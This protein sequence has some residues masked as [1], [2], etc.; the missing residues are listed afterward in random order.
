MTVNRIVQVVATPPF[1]M[2]TGS[3]ILPLKIVSG[4]IFRNPSITLASATPLTEVGAPL[5]RTITLVGKLFGSGIVTGRE[6]S[7][8][9][10]IVPGAGGPVGVPV[11]VGDGVGEGVA[12]G[13]GSIVKLIVRVLVVP[14]SS[15]TDT[16]EVKPP[17]N[18]GV[19]LIVALDVPDVK[20]IPVGNEL[21]AQL[22]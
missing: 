10:S 4:V 7:T 6:P 13:A 17:A 1:V 11:G 22:E 18:D 3:E 15:V 2:V 5:A 16:R 12:L 19:P 21:A 14:K 9:A 8:R 20:T